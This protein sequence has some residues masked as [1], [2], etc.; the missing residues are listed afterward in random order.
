MAEIH[1][2]DIRHTYIFSYRN[3]LDPIHVHKPADNRSCLCLDYTNAGQIYP[4][5]H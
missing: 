4:R 2:L 3:T 1:G 5:D